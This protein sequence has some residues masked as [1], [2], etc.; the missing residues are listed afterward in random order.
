MQTQRELDASQALELVL[1]PYTPA[2]VLAKLER[3]AAEPAT[4]TEYTKPVTCD[5]VDLFN[6]Q[7]GLFA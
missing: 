5:Q 6:T 2:D 4:P 7:G 1:V 3:D